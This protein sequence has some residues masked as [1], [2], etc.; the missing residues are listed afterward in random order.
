MQRSSF[1][2]LL[3]INYISITGNIATLLTDTCRC[4][5]FEFEITHRKENTNFWQEIFRYLLHDAAKQHLT[6]V[7]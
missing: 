6:I 2:V 7:L 1:L 3:T 5:R 4:N